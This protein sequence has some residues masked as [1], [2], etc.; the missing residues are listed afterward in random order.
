MSSN[1]ECHRG[2][3]EHHQVVNHQV[4]EV[5]FF[6]MAA[7]ENGFIFSILLVW[8]SHPADQYSASEEDDGCDAGDDEVPGYDGLTRA[9]CR[10]AIKTALL[11]IKATHRRDL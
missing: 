11:V 4:G 5:T 9:T 2:Y 8:S 7:L 1:T 6:A 3:Q 10:Q